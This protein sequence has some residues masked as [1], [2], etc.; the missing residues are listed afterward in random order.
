MEVDELTSS[1]GAVT[2]HDSGTAAAT[3]RQ[4][5][6]RP[7]AVD[8]LTASFRA[9]TMR[10]AGAAAGIP[11]APVDPDE[12]SAGEEACTLRVR[13]PDGRII[14]KS[15]GAG[16][17]VTALFRYCQSALAAGYDGAVGTRPFRL[18]TL[19]GG[20]TQEIRPDESPLRDLGMHHCTVHLVFCV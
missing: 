7:M 5:A 19:A 16:R 20:A 10:D 1:F 13:F 12:P 11:V 9:V 6:S 15:F 18:V 17:P 2:M 4:Q 3:I 14:C 8:D